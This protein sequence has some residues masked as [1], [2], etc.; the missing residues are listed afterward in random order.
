MKKEL[1]FKDVH[2]SNKTSGGV[3]KAT[4]ESMQAFHDLL[5]DLKFDRVAG[6][7]SAGEIGLFVLLPRVKRQLTLIDHSYATMA[8]ALLKVMLIKEVGGRRAH[9]L[10]T[11]S[12]TG[13]DYYER[14]QSPTSNKEGTELYRLINTLHKRLPESVRTAGSDARF[15]DTFVNRYG[16]VHSYIKAEWSKLKPEQVEEAEKK[17]DLVEFVHGDISDLSKRRPYDLLYLSN[18]MQYA[19]RKGYI[20]P[21][22]LIPACVKPGGY[23]MLTTGTYGMSGEESKIR[24]VTK[25][26]KN[27]QGRGSLGWL[28]YLNQ[29]SPAT[30]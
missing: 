13:Y 4:N 19:G 25:E 28:H 15:P 27:C 9:E 26:V 17:L 16:R 20:I 5:G 24:Q 1:V 29:Y 11:K 14:E 22:K 2:P 30:A 6:I 12:A 8:F 3:Y 18:A 21:E 7:C 10:I 23:V